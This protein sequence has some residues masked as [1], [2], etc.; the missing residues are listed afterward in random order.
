MTQDGQ[1]RA[2]KGGII[3]KNGE[4]YEGGKFL[5]NTERA[6]QSPAKRK[7]GSGKEE[8]APYVWEVAPAEGMRPIFKEI[9]AGFINL[10][11]G[12]LN[13]AACEYYGRDPERVKA[14]WKRWKDGERWFTPEATE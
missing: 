10:D 7:K 13:A 3:G 12:E 1:T 8:I 14:F 6:K 4:F 9:N 5:P 2:P 11:S